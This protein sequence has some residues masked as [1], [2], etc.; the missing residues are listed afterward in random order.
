LLVALGSVK[1]MLQSEQSDVV[2]EV[3]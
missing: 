3:A 2:A 1:K